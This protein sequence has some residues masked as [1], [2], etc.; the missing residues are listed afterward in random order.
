MLYGIFLIGGPGAGTIGMRCLG[1]EVRSWQG[2]RPTHLQAAIM[3]ALFCLITPWT[4]GLALLIGLFSDRIEGHFREMFEAN[5]GKE[6]AAQLDMR[7]A[8]PENLEDW[9]EAAG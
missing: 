6:R 2:A 5:L 4:A 7:I 8:F 9:I 3:S 1:L